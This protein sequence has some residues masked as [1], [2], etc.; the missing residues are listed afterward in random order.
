ML[1]GPGLFCVQNWY[2]VT[3]GKKIYYF[4]G[5]LAITRNNLIEFTNEKANRLQ[6]PKNR[7]TPSGSPF[8]G[9]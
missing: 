3:L 8:F 4:W 6:D 2:F 1:W 9:R 5:L 7:T